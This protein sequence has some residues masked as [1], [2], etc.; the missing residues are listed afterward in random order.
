MIIGWKGSS[1]CL[2]RQVFTIIYS[3]FLHSS[4]RSSTPGKPPG[5]PPAPH[6]NH[7]Q[8]APT[9]AA[10]SFPCPCQQAHGFAHL[11]PL[12]A[13]LHSSSSHQYVCVA[14]CSASTSS[15]H[16]KHS[17]GPRTPS[18]ECLFRYQSLI[19]SPLMHSINKIRYY[20]QLLNHV[21]ITNTNMVLSAF[22]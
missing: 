14:C 9:G 6:L 16:L 11:P 7:H 8:P 10:A 2:Y 5:P 3:L 18:W 17:A 22:R 1:L 15:S 13:T 20:C 12:P 19:Q 4:S 21:I